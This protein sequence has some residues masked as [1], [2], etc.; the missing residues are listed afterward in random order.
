MWNVA[1]QSKAG[2]LAASAEAWEDV[3]ILRL[4]RRVPL[5]LEHSVRL[6]ALEGLAVDSGAAMEV[7]VFEE[8]IAAAIALAL[9]E[10]LVIR[11]HATAS[12]DRLHQTLPPVPVVAGMLVLEAAMLVVE[13]MREMPV[14]QVAQV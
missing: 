3:A 11:A 13:S 10:G 5:D 12:V 6:L 2:S 9:V 8:D 7:E 4:Y 1:A 14:P